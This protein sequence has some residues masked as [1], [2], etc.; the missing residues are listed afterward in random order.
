M[1]CPVFVG[2]IGCNRTEGRD[3]VVKQ[4]DSKNN[5]IRLETVQTD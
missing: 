3:P 5:R 1:E 4:C 2:V